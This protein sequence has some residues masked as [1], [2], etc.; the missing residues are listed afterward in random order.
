M[1]V[2]PIYANLEGLLKVIRSSQVSLGSWVTC[3]RINL[4]AIRLKII[5]VNP[6][7]AVPIP[8]VKHYCQH[9]HIPTDT[10]DSPPNSFLFCG[11]RYALRNVAYVL[12]SDGCL[13]A[14]SMSPLRPCRSNSFLKCTR[15]KLEV[16]SNTRGTLRRRRRSRL[17]RKQCC[18]ILRLCFGVKD[19]KMTF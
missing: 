7:S 12:P 15:F 1:D 8:V 6:I 2:V 5:L 16:S 17:N 18:F 19:V 11:H 10:T 13:F 9:Q 14:R 3:T 4:E